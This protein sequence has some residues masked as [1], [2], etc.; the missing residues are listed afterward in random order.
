MD[1]EDRSLYEQETT[2]AAS[3]L[4]AVLV[5]AHGGQEVV[6][7]QFEASTILA[8]LIDGAY[9]SDVMSRLDDF[10]G[11]VARGD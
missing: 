8:L 3:L 7:G 9:R 1:A 2:S 4:D 5:V 6:V 10:N 11:V